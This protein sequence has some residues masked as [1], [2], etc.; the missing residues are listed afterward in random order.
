MLCFVSPDTGPFFFNVKFF[1][2]RPRSA[3][4]RIFFNLWFFE[5]FGP[6]FFVL[7]FADIPGPLLFRPA[8]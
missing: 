4:N 1:Q 3:L 5:V 6:V 8:G 2:V 7:T